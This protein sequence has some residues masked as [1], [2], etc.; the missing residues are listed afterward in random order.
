MARIGTVFIHTNEK[1]ILGA[2]VS[3]YSM[4]RNSAHADR[5]DVRIVNHKD[6]PF[7]AAREG[8]EF[9]REGGTRVWRNDDLQ[10]F[11][12]L[13]FM[14]PELAGYAG[15]AVVTDP[16]VF[17][18]G[19]IFEL[20]DRDMGGKAILCKARGGS[21]R[22]ASSVM[23][24][25]C[26]RLTHW[27]CEEQFAELFAFKRDYMDWISLKCEDEETIGTFE[28]EWN[29]F[30][31]LN[32]NTRLLHNTRRKTQPWKT[33]L[34]VDF[35]EAERK[36]KKPEG[37]LRRLARG[38]TGGG[39]PTEKTY[40]AH[41]DAQQERFFF[42][43]VRECLDKGIVSEDLLREQMRLNHV[44]HDAFQVIERLDRPAAA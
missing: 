33:G 16:D 10:S 1:Q 17:A 23:L 2:L 12:P 43:L 32:E 26:A 14:P 28:E 18:V 27:K 30:D 31:T 7:F 40:V 44:R 6:F 35:Q 42:G 39:G 4:R 13:R 15:K 19:D 36:G 29:H 11:T 37:L 25:D 21:K 22:F 5:F 3:A 24:L 8:Q 38:L 41:P 34:P 9:L 20:L